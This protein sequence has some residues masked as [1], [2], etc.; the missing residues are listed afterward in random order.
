MSKIV[1]EEY[2]RKVGKVKSITPEDVSNYLG[3]IHVETVRS[4]IKSGTCPFGYVIR[5]EGQRRS[6]FYI[7]VEQLIRFKNGELAPVA[8]AHFDTATA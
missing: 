7:N 2:L 3:N 8:A 5:E 6:F 1:T 4:W